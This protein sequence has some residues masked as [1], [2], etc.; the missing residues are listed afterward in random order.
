[1]VRTHLLDHGTCMFRNG[2]YLLAGTV[3]RQLDGDIDSGDMA[4]IRYQPPDQQRFVDCN[5]ANFTQRIRRQNCRV[6]HQVVDDQVVTLGPGMLVIGQRVDTQRI[7]YLPR[8]RGQLCH[9]P[10]RLR[11]KDVAI[12]RRQHKQDIV[13]LGIGILQLLECKQLRIVITEKYAVIGLERQKAPATGRQRNQQH[14][15]Q[16]DYIAPAN[17]PF[18]ICPGHFCFSL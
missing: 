14:G 3:I 8:L 4:R 11:C 12:L 5:I 6:R 2:R 9:G 17:H 10:Q 1:M 7:R 16:H 15:R 13:G 18:S